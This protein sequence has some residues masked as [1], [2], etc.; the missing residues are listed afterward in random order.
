MFDIDKLLI[1]VPVAVSL[2]GCAYVNGDAIEPGQP[3]PDGII[4][5]TQKPLIVVEGGEMRVELIPNTDQSYAL[6]FGAFLANNDIEVSLNPN[7]T[8][9]SVNADLSSEAALDE[10]G[11]TIGSLGL[12]SIA[13]PVDSG[14]LDS[15]SKAKPLEIFDVV[16]G[17]NGSIHC[18]RQLYPLGKGL[19]QCPPL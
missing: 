9:K 10:I 7:G 4:I 17:P 16:F 5:A 1:A 15:S 3:R 19:D 18:L 11:E 6:R 13:N 14:G 8:L 12:K 2:A